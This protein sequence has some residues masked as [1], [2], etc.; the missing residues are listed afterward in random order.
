VIHS[1][2][3]ATQRNDART[4]ITGSGPTDP[5]AI[6]YVAASAVD[7]SVEAVSKL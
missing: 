2:F 1:Q 7:S 3:R 5:K 6:G 4:W